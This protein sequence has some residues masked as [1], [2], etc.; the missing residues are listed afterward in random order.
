MEK[1]FSLIVFFIFLFETTVLANSDLIN[2]LKKEEKIIFIRHALAPGSGDPVGFSLD[3]CTTQRNLDS[4]GIKQS[5]QIGKFFKKNKIP[6]G[7][8]LSSEWCRCKDTARYAFKKYKTFSLLNSFFDERFQENKDKQIKDL[9]KYLKTRKNKK[10]LVLITHYVVILNLLNQTTSSG[11]AI[12][13]DA[14]LKILGKIR[15]FK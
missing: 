2:S 4:E 14:D 3:D 10:N 12:V 9:K 1:K 13:T 15:D 6:L 7:D 8:V 5:K 11:E